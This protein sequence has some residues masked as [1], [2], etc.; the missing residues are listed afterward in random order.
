[1]VGDSSPARPDDT[2]SRRA[3]R[4]GAAGTRG[5]GPPS[6]APPLVARLAAFGAII[7]AGAC[8]ALIGFGFA[9]LQCDGSCGTQK[10]I[11]ALVGALGAAVGVAIIAVLTLRAM[12]E[13][14]AGGARRD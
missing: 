14:A 13:W 4:T 11:G 2:R 3:S 6:G 9:D 5:S 8:G 12:G 10:G 7:A 1:M